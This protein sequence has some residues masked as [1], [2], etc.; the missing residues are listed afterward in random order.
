M[1]RVNKILLSNYIAVENSSK[2]PVVKIAA[3]SNIYIYIYINKLLLHVVIK[4]NL[5]L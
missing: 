3:N 4:F 2:P 5:F 1:I